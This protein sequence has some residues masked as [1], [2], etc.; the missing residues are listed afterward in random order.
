MRWRGRCDP[1]SFLQ[2]SEGATWAAACP[3]AGS[4]G[5]PAQGGRCSKKEGKTRYKTG[6]NMVDDKNSMRLVKKEVSIDKEMGRQ[7]NTHHGDKHRENYKER[8][9]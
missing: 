9:V 2:V 6:K 1:T 3:G 5:W 8:C 7:V 4:E